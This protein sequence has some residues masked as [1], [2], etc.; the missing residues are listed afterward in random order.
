M[1]VPLPT[2]AIVRSDDLGWQDLRVMLRSI[3]GVVVVGEVARAGDACKMIESTR[4]DV[5]IAAARIESHPVRELID[6]FRQCHGGDPTIVVITTHCLVEDLVSLFNQGVT[7]YLVWGDLHFDEMYHCL[8]VVIT[9]GAVVAS[10]TPAELFY[11]SF[12]Y[13]P[14]T[15]KS[16]VL[17]Q[18][19]SA[20]LSGLA[21]DLSRDEIA[22]RE[23]ISQRTVKRIIASLLEKLDASSPVA[24][25]IKAERYGLV[26]NT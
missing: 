1:S 22:D 16:T 20:V 8:S 10:R 6:G 9:G 17:T 11:Q 23:Q 5:L 15:T 26:G 18:R 19:E 3:P 7:A 14:P 12:R 13:H 21:L 4:P 24:L 25:G 2:V